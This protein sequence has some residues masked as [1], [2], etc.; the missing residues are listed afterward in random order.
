MTQKILFI[1]HEA[2]RTGAPIALLHFLK[3]FKANTATS[4]RVLLKRDGILRSQFESVASVSVFQLN[5][6]APKNLINRILLRLKLKRKDI[7]IHLMKLKTTLMREQFD[8]IYTNTVTNGELLEFLDE[9][10]CPVICHIHELEHVIRYQTGLENFEKVKRYTHHYIAASKAVRD[11]L[12]ENHNILES[13]ISVVHEFI[14]HLSDNIDCSQSNREKLLRELGIPNEAKIICASGTTDWRK[15]PDLF[16][17]LAR[18]INK[19][20]S[21]PVYFI[22]VGGENQGIR[23]GELW[24]DVKNAGL[25]KYVYFLGE[26]TNPHEYFAICDLFTLVSR[27]DPYPLVCLEAASLGKPIVCFDNAGGEKEFVED[28]CGFVIPYLDIQMMADKVMLL[29]N[30]PDLHH[31]FSERAKE[32]VLE[33]H[34]VQIASAQIAQ[35]I[36]QVLAEIN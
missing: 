24:H 3:W 17:Q 23:Y 27:E 21:K 5:N 25:E 13:K 28:D 31:K 12:I 18:L 32:K 6:S 19:Q 4:F 35:I 15:G 14:P 22:W 2:S 33:R 16:I 30:S 36:E 1:S 26:Q 34:D 11:N 8:L 9:I 7:D 10:K 29:L 20:S